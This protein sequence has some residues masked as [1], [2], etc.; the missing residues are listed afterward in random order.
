LWRI[1]LPKVAGAARGLAH[2]DPKSMRLGPP[3][4]NARKLMAASANTRSH[5]AEAK[6]LTGSDGPVQPMIV[7]K[8]VSAI[9][10]PNDPIVKPRETSKLDY[11]V[12]LG[13]VIGR[14]ARRIRAEH[15]EEYLAGYVTVNDVAAR[16][17]QLAE[18]ERNPVYRVQFLGKSF[19]TFAPMGPCLVTTDEIRLGTPLR[20]RTWV[21]GELR[22]DSDITDMIF[23]VADL[24]A[25]VSQVLTLWPGDIITMGS[26]AG[27]GA[28]MEPATF[29]EPGQTVTCEIDRIGKLH[30]PVVSESS[31]D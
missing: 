21:D 1:D 26:P 23:G 22:Q 2:L 29:L 17:V 27:L 15:V 19:D 3:I 12:T 10:G 14:A 16:D 4:P 6:R 28:F 9:S 5:V 24:V 11:G 7:A 20:L 13:I 8:A 18:Y 30:N 31:G 25:Y